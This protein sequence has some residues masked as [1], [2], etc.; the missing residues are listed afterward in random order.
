MLHALGMPEDRSRPVDEEH[1]EVGVAALG[2][3]AEE[4]AQAT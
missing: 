1:A 2:D 4:S 3:P